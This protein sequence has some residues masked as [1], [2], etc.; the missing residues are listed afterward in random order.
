[1]TK[2]QKSEE[3]TSVEALSSINRTINVTKLAQDIESKSGKEKW[4]FT[5][6][7]SKEEKEAYLN[8]LKDRDSQMV[9]GVFKCLE[10]VGGSV[11]FSAKAWDGCEINT[12]MEHGQ[13]YTVPYAIA[14]QLERGCWW[15]THSYLLDAQGKPVITTGKKNYR[16]SFNTSDIR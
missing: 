3:V 14:V 1:M 6:K 12:T 4:E 9:T 13:E 10:P 15:P 8:Y 16:F 11:T 5:R 7:L 2:L